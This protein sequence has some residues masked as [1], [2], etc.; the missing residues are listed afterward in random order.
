MIIGGK[1][2]WTP[3]GIGIT[4]P[5]LAKEKTPYQPWAA[6]LYDFR[7]ANE[8]EPHTRCKPSGGARQF[9]TPYGVE[10][11]ELPEIQRIYI[12]DIGGP[13][14][15]RTIYTDGRKHPDHLQPTYYGHSVGHWEGDT[16]V[17]D[18][19][20]F[21]EAFWMDRRGMPTTDK[22]HLVEKFTR[23]SKERINYEITVDDPG[24]YTAPWTTGFQLAWQ[25]GQEL[26][27]YVCQQSN[28]AGELMVGAGTH[29]DRTSPIVP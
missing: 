10:F 13:H 18:T 7:Q 5:I 4:A 17:V 24:A 16:L 25:D 21:N 8:L 22:L 12:F 29:V 14:T 19:V 28:Y 2:V 3:S 23:T 1:G 15:F 20:G 26:F 6:A 11:V 9:L 27:E